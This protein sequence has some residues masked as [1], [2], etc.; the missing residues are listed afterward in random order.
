MNYETFSTVT[1]SKVLLKKKRTK[2][3]I[4]SDVIIQS[5]ALHTV[6]FGKHK[7]GYFCLQILKS[8]YAKC[9]LINKGGYD[10]TIW[11]ARPCHPLVQVTPGEIASPNSDHAHKFDSD[12][13]H[14]FNIRPF[15]EKLRSRVCRWFLKTSGHLECGAG[16][17]ELIV[18]VI[19]GP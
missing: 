5:L 15:Y 12:V 4:S 10:S 6:E 1:R 19:M 17:L 16:S 2:Y 18:I 3:N 7:T 13:D 8:G 14:C 9:M 11:A